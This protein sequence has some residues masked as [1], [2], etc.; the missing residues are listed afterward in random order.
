[1]KSREKRDST[2]HGII[3]VEL[4]EINLEDEYDVV[5]TLGEGYF[6]KVSLVTHKKSDTTVV[7][8]Q[9]HKELTSSKDFFREYHYNYHLSP[10]PNILSSYS[11]CFLHNNCYTYALEF[12]PYGDL[13]GFVKAGGLPE[14]DCKKITRQITSA[15]EFLHSK[16]LVHRDIKLENILVFDQNMEKVK[17]SDF[18]STRREGSLV[19]KA[20]CSWTSFQPPEVCEIVKNEKYYCQSANDTWQLG[21]VIFVCLTGCSPWEKAD[22]ILDA[23]Y[24]AFSKWQQRRVIK[25]PANFRKFSVRLLRLFRR[26]FENKPEKRPPVTETLKYLKDNWVTSKLSN[27]ASSPAIPTG[28]SHQQKDVENNSSENRGKSKRLVS[29]YSLET[30]VDQN[31][32]TK[33]IWEWISNCE[34]YQDNS[35]EGI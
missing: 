17:L 6:A 3:E 15:L 27:S 21:V 31:L 5:K 14:N 35:Y 24:K 33:R 20:K 10:H 30:K 13:A 11:V 34:S 25:M 16:K 12:A 7:L 4:E 8:K 9:I 19:S 18:G 22:E 1:M 2:I 28:K 26:L 23:Q 32:I 29:T